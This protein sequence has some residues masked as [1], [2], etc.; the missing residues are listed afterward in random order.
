MSITIFSSL[1]WAFVSFSN[2]YSTTLRVPV[3]VL[4][5][6]QGYALKELSNNEV[7]LSVKGEGWELAQLTFGVDHSLNI[8][9][10]NDEMNKTVSVRNVLEQN[11]WVSSKVQVTLVEPEQVSYTLEEINYKE[12]GITSNI[13]AD[14]KAGYG[15]VADVIIEPDTV[16]IS[17][18]KSLVKSIQSISTDSTEFDNLDD[19]FAAEVPLIIPG[20]VS[21]NITKARLSLD[22][23]KIVDK[24]FVDIAVERRGVPPSRELS[25]FPD[26]V[27]VVLRGGIKMLG[28]L[29]SEDISLHVNFRQALEDTLGS[30]EPH[31]IIPEFTS[32]VDIRPGRLDYIIKQF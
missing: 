17:G 15:L 19:N 25:L 21:S 10:M 8:F 2:D 22:V 14:F 26:R 7:S 27:N 30:I 5:I 16:R 20:G 23:Q 4:N 11:S 13:K 31:I 29:K 32:L 1:L 28:R 24:M 3:N 9:A 6:P 18:A 12:V